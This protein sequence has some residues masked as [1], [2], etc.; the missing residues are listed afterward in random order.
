MFTHPSKETGF[1][2][3]EQPRHNV[4]APLAGGDQQQ[5]YIAQLLEQHQVA[6]ALAAI[7]HQQ[8]SVAAA[9]HRLQREVHNLKMQQNMLNDYWQQQQGWTQQQQ[10]GE[11]AVAASEALHAS[12]NQV[13]APAKHCQTASGK[14]NKSA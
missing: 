6:M 1:I 8:Q 13:A 3:G 11:H 9:N 7:Q 12:L 14:E 10:R 2:V 4:G 5:Q